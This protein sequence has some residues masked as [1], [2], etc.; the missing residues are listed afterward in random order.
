MSL[1]VKIKYDIPYFVLLIN[2]TTK[3][4]IKKKALDQIFLLILKRNG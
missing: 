1:T 2:K 3:F 4:S